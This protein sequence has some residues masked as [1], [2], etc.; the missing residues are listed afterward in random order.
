MFS[1]EQTL[2]LAEEHGP[3]FYLVDIE[4]FRENFSKLLGAFKAHYTNTKIAYSYKTNYL[5]NLC[6]AVNQLWGHA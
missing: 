6:A 1:D 2:S 3:S 5:P 4:K